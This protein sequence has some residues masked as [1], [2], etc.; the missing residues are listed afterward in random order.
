MPQQPST[1]ALA[2]LTQSSAS[3]LPS[4]AMESLLPLLPG[5][6][7]DFKLSGFSLKDGAG[8]VE[9]LQIDPLMALEQVALR[10]TAQQRSAMCKHLTDE[11]MLAGPELGALVRES[12]DPRSAYKIFVLGYL[13]NSVEELAAFFGAE[14]KGGSA[15]LAD[16]LFERFGGFTIL[17][18]T[19]FFDRCR[20]GYYK[21]EFENIAVRG[22][23]AQFLQ[24]WAV[25]FLNEGDAGAKRMKAR[26]DAS[27][28]GFATKRA[29][30][31]EMTDEARA[32][33]AARFEAKRIQDA[34]LSRL[35][36]E[37]AKRRAD[38]EHWLT[39]LQIFEHWE[40][41]VEEMATD[42]EGRSVLVKKW[43]VCEKTHSQAKRKQM[44][45]VRR[46]RKEAAYIR[47]VD[48]FECFVTLDADSAVVLAKAWGNFWKDKWHFANAENPDAY[49]DGWKAYAQ[50][51]AR[52]IWRVRHRLDAK[53]LLR[54]LLAGKY[55]DAPEKQIQRE[56]QQSIFE[57]GQ[58]WPDVLE[59][60]LSVEDAVPMTKN[61]WLVQQVVL[62]ARQNDCEHPLAEY[63]I[64]HTIAP[65]K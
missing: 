49:P 45:Q 53:S 41:Q 58:H 54:W 39:E 23:N 32:A 17:E 62:W 29:E 5:L 51:E 9:A 2:R 65:T 33:I 64:P 55:P 63:L 48:F 35:E 28:S 27:I 38:H 20:S 30:I 57:W 10:G 56:A 7:A 8:L 46:D 59:K 15:V 22:I 19:V 12:A 34:R 25:K 40:R 47:L 43:V 3:D 14:A 4:A 16:C 31:A 50:V 26:M 42:N 44:N 18:W 37:A 21:T 6:A 52:R 11:A 1:K 60:A 36:S 24:D 61:E 13:V